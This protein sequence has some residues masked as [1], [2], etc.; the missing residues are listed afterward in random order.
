MIDQRDI[1]YVRFQLRK[2]NKHNK[3]RNRSNIN[4]ANGTDGIY[5]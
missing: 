1:H 4:E 3:P 2:N 5:A